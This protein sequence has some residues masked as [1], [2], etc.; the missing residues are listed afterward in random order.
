MGVSRDAKLLRTPSAIGVDRRPG[1]GETLLVESLYEHAGGAEAIHRLEEVFYSKVLADP[2][3]SRL[4][5]ARIATHADHLTAFTGESFGGP[6]TFTKELGFQY[7]IDVHRGLKITEEER[8]RFVRLYLEAA[9]EVGFPEDPPFRQAL[10]EHLEFGSHVAM[11]N[12][13]AETD[14][15]LHPIRELPRWT[16]PEP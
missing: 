4:F 12:S 13:N 6:D 11:Q 15:E 9:E 10:R 7:I 1:K 2:L 16:W 5:P 8:Q 3:L 14:D